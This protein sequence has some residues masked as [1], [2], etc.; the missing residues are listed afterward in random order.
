[1]NKIS[2]EIG[3]IGSVMSSG[4]EAYLTALAVAAAFTGGTTYTIGKAVGSKWAGSNTPDVLRKKIRKQN[5]AKFRDDL[6]TYRDLDIYQEGHT[7]PKSREI[8]I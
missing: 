1:M 3:D 2:F 8:H 7:Q 5:L 6:A 4:V